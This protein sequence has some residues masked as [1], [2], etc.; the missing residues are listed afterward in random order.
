MFEKIQDALRYSE[1]I[2]KAE[3]YDP[4][5]IQADIVPKDIGVYL[6]RSKSNNEIVYV[7]RALGKAGLYQ[8][9]IRQHLSVGYTKSVFRKQIAEEFG[10]NPKEESASFIR[11]NFIFSFISLDRK[12]KNIASFVEMSL[13][14]E[15]SPKY[16]REGKY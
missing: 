12:D 8:R 11:D 3:C 15:Y 1:K 14:F 16:N 9:I 6:W 13:I 4:K 2:V 7:G 5:N 10:L